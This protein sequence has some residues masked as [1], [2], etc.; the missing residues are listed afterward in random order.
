[1]YLTKWIGSV[2]KCSYIL[3]P[4]QGNYVMIGVTFSND[5]DVV[6]S[7]PYLK[8]NVNCLLSLGVITLTK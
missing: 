7:K 2:M 1:M 6:N 4:S 8:T 3:E 5:G